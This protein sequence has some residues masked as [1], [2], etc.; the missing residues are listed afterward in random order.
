L[1][2]AQHAFASLPI[3]RLAITVQAD[4]VRAAR[5]LDRLL[6]RE[7]VQQRHLNL[8]GV[9]VDLLIYACWREDLPRLMRSA[10]VGWGICWSP[11][12]SN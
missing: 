12:H 4:N 5:A 2:F 6:S 11:R 1:L 3:D 10:G 8:G 7:G 9:W